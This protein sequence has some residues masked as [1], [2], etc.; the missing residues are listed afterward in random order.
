MKEV[1]QSVCALR[2]D[3]REE[4]P[5]EEVITSLVED[6]RQ[7]TGISTSTRI[8]LS[9]SIP[10]QV[11]KT[12]YRVVQEALTN[13][14]KHAQ[15]TE[16][17]IEV[18]T[19]SDSV[20]LFLEDNGKGFRLDHQ[21]ITGFGLQGMRERVAA[22]DGELQFEAEPKAGCR[23]TIKLPLKAAAKTLA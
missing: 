22:L 23:I 10:P 14:Y 11:V 3:A 15:A 16:V 7:G 17:K 13:I 8:N 4:Q 1:R 20:H 18:S 2:A 9:T 5:L 19:T 12:L 6:F 21:T